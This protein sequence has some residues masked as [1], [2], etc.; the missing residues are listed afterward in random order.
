MSRKTINFPQPVIVEYDDAEFYHMIDAH[1]YP[2]FTETQTNQI[3]DSAF[4]YVRIVSFDF[5]SD[6]VPM[7]YE[8]IVNH[9]QRQIVRELL[10]KYAQ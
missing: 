10:Q 4:A 2:R 3:I 8:D 1:D 6:P 5:G 9:C 7:L